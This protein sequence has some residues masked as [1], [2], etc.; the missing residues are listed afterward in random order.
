MV[1]VHTVVD[2]VFMDCLFLLL[3][4]VWNLWN[5]VWARLVTLGFMI[6]CLARRNVLGPA[7]LLLGSMKWFGPVD[8]LLGSIKWVGLL[9][10]SWVRWNDLGPVDLLLGSMKRFGPV[11]LLLV[12]MICFGSVDLLLDS[13]K[14]FELCYLI[15]GWWG[16]LCLEVCFVGGLNLD[17]CFKLITHQSSQRGQSCSSTLLSCSV[18]LSRCTTFWTRQDQSRL[19]MRECT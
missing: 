16:C 5:C 1:C 18:T 6:C 7:D 2:F 10:C 12:L 15:F 11:D 19:Q 17:Y 8:L 4:V 14:C 13:V 9:I 3:L